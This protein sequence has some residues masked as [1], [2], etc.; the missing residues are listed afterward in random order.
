MYGLTRFTLKEMTACGA[1][2]RKLGSGAASMEE[3]ANRLIRYLYDYLVD[4]QTG[5]KTC[6]LVRFFKTHPYQDLEAELQE[7]ARRRLDGQTIP[8]G[9]KCLVLLATA[10]ERAEWR[11]RKDSAA[12]QAIPLVSVKVVEEAPM[13]ATAPLIGI[14]NS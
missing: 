13:I 3:A 7:F 14:G 9:M 11:S 10:G 4:Q 8:R 6:A 2:L 5:A 1:A 12:H